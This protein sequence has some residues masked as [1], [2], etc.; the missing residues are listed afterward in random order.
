MTRNVVTVSP[1]LTLREAMAL[2]ASKHLSGA[3]VVAKGKVLGV[4]SSTD[5]MDLAASLPGEPKLPE[6]DDPQEWA[7]PN[8]AWAGAD[9]N[10]AE[11]AYFSTSWY[12]SR[13]ETEA[14]LRDEGN[15]EWSALDEHTVA[16]AMTR[17]TI[18]LPP[19]TA[20]EFA[21][22]RMRQAGVHRVLVM[23][24]D[25]LVGIVSTKDI[26]DAVADRILTARRFVFVRAK[27]AR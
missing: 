8:G 15:P 18:W 19:G 17:T 22:H 14:R 9:E 25:E 21:A 26:A 3:P 10:D 11:Q 7:E 2:F 20:V 27:A 4:V 6:T 12:T 16:E 13:G 24:G 1:E 23:Q 5:L